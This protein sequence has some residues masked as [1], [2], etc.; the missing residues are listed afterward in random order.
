MSNNSKFRAMAT[1]YR[2]PLT[3]E[4]ILQH[5]NNYEN[6]TPAVFCGSWAKYNEGRALA[7]MWINLVSFDS[8]EEFLEY[9]ERLHCDE[10]DVE[11]A[12]LDYSDFPE[13]WYGESHLEFDS[14]KAWYELDEDDREAFAAYLE[15]EGKYATIEKF[16]EAY[17][18]HFDTPEEF[19]EDL[20]YNTGMM[21][22]V[23]EW[24]MG[25]I[26]WSSIWRNLRCAG[27]YWENKGYYFA[28][29]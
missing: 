25:S 19:A 17:S 11:L 7:G 5:Q 6:N 14:I 28:S 24:V 13:S 15:Y 23:P 27:D 1:M 10:Q 3:A 4:E 22:G 8:Y 26:D 18:G 2:E 20:Y 29:C 12:F 21:E 16:Q 9:C